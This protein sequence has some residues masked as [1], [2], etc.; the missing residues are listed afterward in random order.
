[1]EGDKVVGVISIGDVVKEEI[2]SRE[3]TIE[4]LENYIE[5]HGYGH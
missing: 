4:T 3:S 5:G 2:A 1:L